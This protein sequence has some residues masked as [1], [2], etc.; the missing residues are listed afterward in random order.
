M[1][2][3]LLCVKCGELATKAGT[4]KR[5]PHA[6]LK[7]DKCAACGRTA[8]GYEHDITKTEEK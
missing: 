2:K 6:T 4:A 7:R 8:Y 1:K 5:R 3:Q